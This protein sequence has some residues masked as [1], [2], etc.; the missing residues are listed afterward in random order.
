MKHKSQRSKDTPCLHCPVCQYL[1]KNKTTLSDQFITST[2][3]RLSGVSVPIID[4][5]RRAVYKRFCNVVMNNMEQTLNYE[6]CSTHRSYDASAVNAGEM[7]VRQPS[8]T[9]GYFVPKVQSASLLLDETSSD[10]KMKLNAQPSQDSKVD[11]VDG[12]L[13]EWSIFTVALIAVACLS[14]CVGLMLMRGVSNDGRVSHKF[15]SHKITDAIVRLLS[16]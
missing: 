6:I 13:Y 11:T 12:Q 14:L 5:T 9:R 1:R 8:T 16:S 15:V 10:G 2:L 3:K 4:S 7:N